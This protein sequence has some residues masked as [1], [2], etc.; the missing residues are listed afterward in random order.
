MKMKATQQKGFRNTLL[1]FCKRMNAKIRVID[2]SMNN[3]LLYTTKNNIV[4][5]LR[6]TNER[7]IGK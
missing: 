2:V 3:V 6:D 7:K 4:I 5:K 1:D